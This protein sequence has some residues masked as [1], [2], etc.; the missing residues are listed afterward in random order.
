MNFDIKPGTLCFIRGESNWCT[1]N[2]GKVVTVVRAAAHS[3]GLAK[4][5]DCV[6]KETMNVLTWPGCTPVIL[7]PGEEHVVA[8]AHLL[9]IAGPE[10]EDDVRHYD[11]HLLIG[12]EVVVR[13]TSISTR[14]TANVRR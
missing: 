13:V 11:N 7:A 4:A 14:S 5:W 3:C 10:L 12:K 6:S 2:N 1:P 8:Q 9:P